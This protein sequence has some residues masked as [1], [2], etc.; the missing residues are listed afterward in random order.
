MM[1]KK[2]QN[3]DRKSVPSRSKSKDSALERGYERSETVTANTDIIDVKFAE[4]S[5]LSKELNRPAT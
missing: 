4:S 1:I 3:Y 2:Y 5:S